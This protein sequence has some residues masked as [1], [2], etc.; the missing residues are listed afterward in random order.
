MRRSRKSVQF[1]S[2][3]QDVQAAIG[4]S[5]LF[6][7]T[8]PARSVGLVRLQASAPHPAAKKPKWTSKMMPMSR[9]ITTIETRDNPGSVDAK[10]S[11]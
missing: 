3:C 10:T 4:L 7:V 5:K 6:E 11:L 9:Y 8:D 1:R 2:S